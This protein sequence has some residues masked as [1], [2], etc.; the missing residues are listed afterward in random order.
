[1]CATTM[2][3]GA[4][5]EDIPMWALGALISPLFWYAL[6]KD[7]VDQAIRWIAGRA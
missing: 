4:V 1:M 3:I 7:G 5:R 6:I 2:F